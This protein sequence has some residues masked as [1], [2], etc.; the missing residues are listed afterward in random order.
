MTAWVEPPASHLPAVLSETAPTAQAPFTPWAVL[1]GQWRGCD[2]LDSVTGARTVGG[3]TN[4]L[5]NS[6]PW[7]QLAPPFRSRVF[8]GAA[9]L[10]WPM[11]P[12]GAW[13]SVT[14]VLTRLGSPFPPK[15][16]RWEN[17]G[18]VSGKTCGPGCLSLPLTRQSF[19]R[20]ECAHRWMN[21]THQGSNDTQN[22]SGKQRRPGMRKFFKLQ[23]GRRARPHPNSSSA[24]AQLGLLSGSQPKPCD[25]SQDGPQDPDLSNSSTPDTSL[26]AEPL[27]QPVTEPSLTP[28]RALSAITREIKA[29]GLLFF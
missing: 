12:D 2:L 27:E 11:S 23:K 21:W 20:S 9:K 1:H 5:I 13:Y 18:V 26:T 28:C 24:R 6:V 16:P 4:L 10:R 25:M 8:A 29:T 19:T 3:N 17:A 14:G 15:P 7:R 22:C